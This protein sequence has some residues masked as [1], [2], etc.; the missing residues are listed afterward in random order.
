MLGSFDS[1]MRSYAAGKLHQQGVRLVQ[2]STPELG[3]VAG[4]LYNQ[5]SKAA[6]ASGVRPRLGG[7]HKSAMQHTQHPSSPW[8]AILPQVCAAHGRRWEVLAAGS[9]SSLPGQTSLHHT[10]RM[11]TPLQVHLQTAWTL[12]QALQLSTP[13]QQPW[14]SSEAELIWTGQECRTQAIRPPASPV[15]QHA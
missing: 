2:A 11:H 10:C 6:S 9:S 8:H 1:K 3:A 12:T 4:R 7:A 15:L 5:Q 14:H 13:A